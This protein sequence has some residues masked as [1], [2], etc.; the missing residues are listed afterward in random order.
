[1]LLAILAIGAASASDDINETLT[2]DDMEELSHD[3]DD[4]SISIDNADDEDIL[5]ATV[6]NNGVDSSN[7]TIKGTLILTDLSTGK[8]FEENITVGPIPSNYT[9]ANNTNVSNNITETVNQL[10]N[11]AQ[12]QAGNKVVTIKSQNV[13]GPDAIR[14]DYRTQTWFNDT[15]TGERYCVVDGEYGT[16]WQYNVTVIAEYESDIFIS[17]NASGGN[18]TMDDVKVTGG[19]NFTLPECNFTKE[20]MTF[21]GWNI[22]DYII[23]K[24]GENITLTEDITIKAI[25][26][27]DVEGKE[28][29]IEHTTDD[30]VTGIVGDMELTDKTTGQIYSIVVFSDNETSQYSNATPLNTTI[31]DMIY[32]FMPKFYLEAQGYA[33]NC[34]ITILN[35]TISDRKALDF[36]TKGFITPMN[37]EIPNLT[38]YQHSMKP[39]T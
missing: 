27:G 3:L 31:G 9:H 38:T 33:G 10:L 35:E 1:M 14:Y 36:G 12:I 5:K 11:L 34:T 32:H 26:L 28:A 22:V 13:S 24:P 30:S 7:T 4:E 29:W 21:Y 20:G 37:S 23:K 25:W 8:A 39:E 6:I 16:L 19:G 15:D 17:F 18:G 2:A